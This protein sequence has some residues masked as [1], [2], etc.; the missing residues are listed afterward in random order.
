MHFWRSIHKC[1]TSTHYHFHLLL[2]SILNAPPVTIYVWI[3]LS[4]SHLQSSFSKTKWSMSCAI[5]INFIG[6]NC[7]ICVYLYSS[8]RILG[9]TSETKL[10]P[11]YNITKTFINSPEIW[12]SHRWAIQLTYEIFSEIYESEY[13]N[14]H[15]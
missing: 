4:H 15:R 12:K 1:S 3:S 13:V 2:A 7:L 9:E 14:H 8:W 10:I 5:H 6:N 11:K